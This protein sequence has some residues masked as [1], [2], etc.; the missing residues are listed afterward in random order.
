MNKV[1]FFFPYFCLSI[2]FLLLFY[3][4]YRSIIVYEGEK[5][6]YYIIYYYFSIISIFFSII[7]F[8]ISK[9][10]IEYLI[11]IFFSSIFSLYIFE[12]SFILNDIFSNKEQIYQNLTGKKYDT[13]NKQEIYNELKKSNNS[14]KITLTVSPA[15]ILKLKYDIELFPLS[16]IS[17]TK[18]IHCNENGYYSIYQSD[19]YGFNNPDSEWDSMENEYLIIGDSFAH[20]ACVN[21]PNDIASNLRNLSDKSV[22]NLGFTGN[23]PLIEYATLREYFNFNSKKVLWLYYKNDLQDLK[24]ELNNNILKNYLYN[25]EFT[26][27]LKSKQNHIDDLKE[28]L[29]KLEYEKKETKKIKEAINFIKLRN[30]RSI[31]YFYLPNKYKPKQE[32]KPEFKKILKQTKDFLKLNNTKLYFVYLP[33]KELYQSDLYNEYNMVKKIVNEL[34]IP[35]IDIHKD[36]FALEENPLS[37]F[38]FEYYN[39]YNVEGYKKISKIIYDQTKNDK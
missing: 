11:I 38:P 28:N 5:N 14:E 25:L 3:T 39:H 7:L 27:N 19:R 10:I 6:D 1:K 17:N 22:L 18:T 9:K 13:R 37:Y 8:F 32:I 12:L 21:R 2:S 34:N 31:L 16:N 23:G 29:I 30:V 20:G 4:L 15:T 36:F 26:Q 24:Q 35:F 33:S